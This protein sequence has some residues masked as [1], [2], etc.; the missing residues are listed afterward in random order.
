LAGDVISNRYFFGAN[1]PF[2]E[3]FYFNAIDGKTHNPRDG[4][5]T[6]VAATKGEETFLDENLDGLFTR[7]YK[8]DKCP[9]SDDVICECDGGVAG[10]YAGFVL[11]GE[12]C[13]DPGKSGGMRSEGFIDLPGDPFYDVND[14]GLRDDGQIAGHPFELY[15]DT[16]HNGMFDRANGKW[17]GPGCQTLECEQSKTIWKDAR[18]VFSGGAGFFPLPDANNCYNL[19]TDIAS[20]CTATFFNGHVG[21]AVAPAS[22]P[23]GGSGSFLVLVGDENL[24]TPQGGTTISVTAS[25]LASAPSSTAST[26]VVTVTPSQDTVKDTLSTGPW[27]FNFTINVP[28]DTTAASTT[29]TVEVVTPHGTTTKTLAVIPLN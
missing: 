4:W 5:S 14:D 15:I 23:K 27:P 2:N 25:A 28:L 19:A 10:G 7:S 17:D 26:S 22:I 20:T 1:G 6:I 29:V 24:N 8:N 13:T 3:P 18:I 16:N 21:F 9:Y 12:R 11:Q